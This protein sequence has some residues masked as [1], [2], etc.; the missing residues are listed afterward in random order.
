MTSDNPTQQ[1]RL[2]ALQ[3]LIV[4]KLTSLNQNI[5]LRKYRGFEAAA[6]GT[7]IVRGKQLMDEIRQLVGQME[8]MENT[9]L[10]QRTAEAQ[11]LSRTTT[12]VTV[13]GSVLAAGTV[14][15]ATISLNQDISRRIQV[16]EQ[17]RILQDHLEK[18]VRKRTAQLEAA[19]LAKDEFLSVL[20]HELRTPLN[21]I[22]GW[23]QLLRRGKLD[24]AKA[25]QGLEVIERNARSQARLIED[26]LDI[27]RIIQ[28]KL[29]LNVRS[30]EPVAVVK[31]AIEAMRPAAR[32]GQ[33]A[34]RLYLILQQ[35]QFQEIQSVYSKLFGISSPMPSNSLPSKVGFKSA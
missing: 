5:T 16:E 9:L 8:A 3:P 26:I 6:R 4:A 33:F 7:E 17:L 30:V 29:R 11:T 20:S 13:L 19:S 1:D 32:R 24:P 12:I 22:L 27:S 23:I 2:D 34:Y 10:K 25:T 14:A 28:G 35:D 21:A 18:Q 31:A 15:A